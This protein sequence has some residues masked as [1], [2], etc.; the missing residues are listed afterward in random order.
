MLNLLDSP[1]ANRLHE[2]GQKLIEFGVKP[3]LDPLDT[4]LVFL[5]RVANGH[6]FDDINGRSH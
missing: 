1:T 4:C 3:R 5:N 2:Y 6:A